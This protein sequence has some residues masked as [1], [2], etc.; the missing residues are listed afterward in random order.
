MALRPALLRL[1][2]VALALPL[3]AEPQSVSAA[4]LAR[5]DAG[6][7]AVQHGTR[8]FHADVTQTLHLQ[9]L[10]QPLASMG[11]LDY[12]DPDRLLIRFSKP[13]GEW[14][15]VNGSQTAIQKAGKPL[16]THDLSAQDRSA[17]HAASLLDF[18]H[19]D[20]VRWHKDFDVSMTRDGD[21]L[22]VH[23][24]PWMTPT[25]SSQGVEEVRTTLRLPHYDIVE[26]VVQFNGN[27]SVDYVFAHGLRNVAIDPSLFK[28]PKP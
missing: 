21:A 8:T 17:S 3:R 20:P 15:L 22:T 13:A 27:N 7:A 10:S 4:D 24:K 18:F 1:A 2:L 26:M 28:V 19:A 14:M 23:L 5:H 9:G 25:A 16:E 12:A 11:T 6:F